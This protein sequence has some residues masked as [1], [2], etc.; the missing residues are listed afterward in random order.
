VFENYNVS[1]VLFTNRGT[2]QDLRN[3]RSH[4]W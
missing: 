2:L 3:R 1:D 4:L